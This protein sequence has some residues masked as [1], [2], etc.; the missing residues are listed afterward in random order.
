MFAIEMLPAGHGDALVVEYGDARARSR[1]IVDAGPYSSWDVIRTR[2]LAQTSGSYEAFVITHVDEDHIGGSIALLEDPDL[3][4]RVANVW[5]NGFIHCKIGGNVLGPVNGEQLT[6]RIVGGLFDW[7][8]PFPWPSTV[9][10]HLQ[11]VGAGGPVVVASKGA[12]PVVWLKGGARAVILSPDGPALN[13]LAGVWKKQVLR[14]GLVPGQGDSS[15]TAGPRPHQKEAGELPDVASLQ[16]L[17]G[18]ASV[19]TRDRSPANRSSIAFVIEYDGRRLLLTGDAHPGVLA[20]NLRRYGMM[21]NEG[22]PRIDLVKLPH[23]G[24]GANVSGELL[25]A[26]DA[27]RFL[28]S[29]N[30]DNYGHP[31]DA[32]IARVITSRRDRVTFYCN[33]RGARTEPWQ[34][35]ASQV[36]AEFR[37][38]ARGKTGMRVSV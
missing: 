3:R 5:F 16:W 18:L 19:R 21:L 27:R 1:L 30:G 24:S 6:E 22:R 17:E 7:N 32:A 11:P 29:T 9:P 15:H 12:L 38:P 36:G 14:A 34:R 26:M 35:L 8:S 23:H 25:K 13:Q 33:Y 28:V 4:H 31:D 20:R 2:L 10:D 37:I